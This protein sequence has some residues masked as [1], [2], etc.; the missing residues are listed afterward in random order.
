MEKGHRRFVPL[1]EAAGSAARKKS[2]RVMQTRHSTPI[3][4][5]PEVFQQAI[6]T[7]YDAHRR[8]LPWRAE[9]GVRPDPYRV[10][11][12]EI[13]LQQTT[14]KA[15][16]PYFKVFLERW[17]SI[18][19]LGATS[20][21][22]V[23]AAW[24]GLG[25]YS[26]ARNLHACAREISLSGFPRGEAELRRLPGI[27]VYTAAAIA[28]IAF[29]KPAAAVD[30]NVERVL[31]RLFALAAPVPSVKPQVRSLAGRLTPKNRAGD[32]AQAMMDLGATIC[33]PRAPSCQCCPVQTFC[34]GV[35]QGKPER[36]PIRPPKAARPVRCGDAF[37]IVRKSGKRMHILLRRRPERGLLGAMMEVPCTG[38][39][40]DGG[41]INP[42]V[43]RANW[44]EAGTVRHTFT[45]FQLEMR[46]FAAPYG[47]VAGEAHAFGGEWAAVEELP[48]FALPAVMK[49]AVAA[50]FEALGIADSSSYPEGKAARSASRVATVER[51]A[52]PSTRAGRK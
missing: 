27:G 45:H 2:R 46:V 26:R 44:R 23:L 18:H 34:A 7:W 19:A 38:W 25:Y 32:Y 42:D 43:A 49:K 13:M 10:W 33:T 4:F 36:Y 35:A 52:R 20:L 24:A 28:A 12:S 21:D 29:D 1:A 6:L 3:P 41:N 51:S 14:V 47:Q 16:I 39:A 30:G 50:G 40:V 31:A 15:V 8:E 48:R 22:E 11:L 9:P 5:E 37:V 17:P